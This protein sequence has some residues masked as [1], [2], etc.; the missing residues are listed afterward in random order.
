MERV[1]LGKI[2]PTT[3]RVVNFRIPALLDPFDGLLP[4]E[5]KA[6]VVADGQGKFAGS[7]MV[8]IGCTHP[9]TRAPMGFVY[10]QGETYKGYRSGRDVL[11]DLNDLTVVSGRKGLWIR[12]QQLGEIVE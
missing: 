6:M 4:E 8:Q 3:A 9:I 7:T 12:S 2:D 11:V 1:K 10:R 5:T